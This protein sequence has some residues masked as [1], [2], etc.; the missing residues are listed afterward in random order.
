MIY[1]YDKTAKS[2]SLHE[3]KE[4]YWIELSKILVHNDLNSLIWPFIVK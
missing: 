4:K 1:L 3:F 2:G